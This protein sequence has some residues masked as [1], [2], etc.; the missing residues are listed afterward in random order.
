MAAGEWSGIEDGDMEMDFAGAIFKVDR[1]T[2]A[3]ASPVWKATAKGPFAESTE[4]RIRFDGDDP[5]AACLCLEIIHSMDADS[6][7]DWANIESRV[8]SDRP[9]F[10]AFVDKYD[11]GGVKRLVQCELDIRQEARKLKDDNQ[12]QVQ[13]L[14]SLEEEV[15][16]LESK[17]KQLATAPGVLVNIDEYMPEIGTRVKVKIPQDLFCC[18]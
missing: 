10:D 8:M 1:A 16:R 15:G 5:Q 12:Q 3:R 6:T 17:V 11:L 9:E 7:L 13:K 4:D 2:V 18:S 14:Q